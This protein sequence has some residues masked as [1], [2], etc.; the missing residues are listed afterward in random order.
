MNILSSKDLDHTTQ[1]FEA[2]EYR[3]APDTT[4]CSP[5]EEQT[6]CTLDG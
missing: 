1:D 3:E 5:P 6:F 2:Y 4:H